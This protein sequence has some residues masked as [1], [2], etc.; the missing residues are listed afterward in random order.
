M[1]DHVG[2]RTEAFEPAGLNEKREIMKTAVKKGCCM[3]G[4]REVMEYVRYQGENKG[5]V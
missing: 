5:L 3:D 1:E 2:Y 4:D